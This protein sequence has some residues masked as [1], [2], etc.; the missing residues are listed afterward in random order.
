MSDVQRPLP[1][2]LPDSS[3][4]PHWHSR[5]VLRHVNI[6]AFV[7]LLPVTVVA[8][9][10]FGVSVLWLMVAS[11]VTA[12]GTEAL[13]CRLSDRHPTLKNGHTMLMA[14]VLALTLPPACGVVVAAL[15]A[16]LMVLVMETFGG[17]GH[18]VWH[19]ALVARVVLTVAFTGVMVPADWSVLKRDH[20]LTGRHQPAEAMAANISWFDARGSA[21]LQA[22]TAP[23]PVQV[24]CGVYDPSVP[25]KGS[26]NEI[27]LEVIRDDLPPASDCLW[28]V[29]GGGIGETSIAAILLGGLFLVYRGNVHWTLPAGAVLG[30]LGVAA[31]MPIPNTAQGE[32]FA[33]WPIRL[34]LGPPVLPVGLVLVL[35]HVLVGEFMFAVFFVASDLTA[36]PLRQRGHLY[37]G[38][39][40]GSMTGVLRFAGFAPGACY[41]AIL[42]MNTFVPL[43]DRWTRPRAYGT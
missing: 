43:V 38:F 2:R 22:W 6:T 5:E 15:G 19:P 4:P 33:W 37:Y 23:R 21:G 42:I 11:V 41:W 34:S 8:V 35:Y 20:L 39:G 13:I 36:S 3:H 24:L 40:I 9:L 28:G 7:A 25:R 27:L 12:V 31:C 1:I 17:L 32:T 30:L 29:T 26:A 16:V 18:Y 10:L 14:L